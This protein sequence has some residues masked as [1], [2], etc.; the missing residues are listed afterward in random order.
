MLNY[1]WQ[2]FHVASVDACDTHKRRKKVSCLDS[3]ER[4][5]GYSKQQ[6]KETLLREHEI[7]MTSE[8]ETVMSRKTDRL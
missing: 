8:T 7:L 6:R 2:F 4:C 1:I 3:A 5:R